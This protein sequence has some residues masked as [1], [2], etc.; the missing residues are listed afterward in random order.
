MAKP[1]IP[2]PHEPPNT[3]AEKIPPGATEAAEERPRNGRQRGPN[4][5]MVPERTIDDPEGVE[6][7]PER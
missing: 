6:P 3:G 4:E 2:Y 5:D 7:I 1:Q